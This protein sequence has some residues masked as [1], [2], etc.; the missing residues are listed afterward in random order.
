MIG[1]PWSRVDLGRVDPKR[2]F[3]PSAAHS[4][5][6]SNKPHNG[7]SERVVVLHVP[8]ILASV[9]GYYT[10]YSGVYV[11]SAGGTALFFTENEG[12]L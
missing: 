1:A 2:G 12:V 4:S 7:A 11:P 6:E 5:G 10:K 9:I 8:R 3:A